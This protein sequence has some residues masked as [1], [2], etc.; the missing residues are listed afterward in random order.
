MEKIQ[1]LS[2]NEFL[3]RN[4][5]EKAYPGKPELEQLLVYNVSR[6]LIGVS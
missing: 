1:F 4:K 3:D 5:P 2:Q 6:L